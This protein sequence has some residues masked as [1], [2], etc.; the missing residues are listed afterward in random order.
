M[1]I[2]EQGLFLIYAFCAL[3]L[4]VYGMNCYVMVLLFLRV[5]R[6]ER[7]HWHEV[8]KA[9]EELWKTP[10]RLPIVTTQIPIFNEANVS[11]RIIRA[12]AAMD[13]PKDLHEIQVL[14]DSTDETK[15]LV[16]EV[17]TS[18]KE[19]GYRIELFHRTNRQGYKAGALREGMDVCAGEFIAIFDADFVP[20]QN[21]LRQMV[22]AIMSDSNLGF[23]QARWG[24][25]NSNH[26]L[27]TRSQTIGIDGHFMIEQCARAY[28]RLFL[29]FNGTA[30]LWRKQ[31]I[32]EAGNWQ[33]DTL[34][35]DMD[36]SYRC[37]LAGWDASYVPDVVVPAELPESY[38]A[39]KSQQF[40]WAKGSIQT[41]IKILP[42]V[43]CSKSSMLAKMQAF[44]HLT[45]YSIHPLMALMALLAL[46]VLLTVSVS[47][48]DWL[49]YIWGAGIVASMLGPSAM[50]W[51]SQMVQGRENVKR[52]WFLPA[53]MCVGVGIALSNTRAVLEAITRRKSAFV[54]TPKSGLQT[55]VYR[56]KVGWLPLLEV[57]LGIYCFS[58][59]FVYMQSGKY[60]VGPF[61][62]IYA[63]G[64][65][66]VGLRSLAESFRRI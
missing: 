11:E 9:G 36:L 42:R 53:L 6:R 27:L 25:L 59:L 47:V 48:P 15:L 19:E 4:L 35:E 18:L 41:A 55:K 60:L 32:Y 29:N 56:S 2:L 62:L 23:L 13:Y 20:P 66:F 45:H 51:V 12:V 38:A 21:Y 3:G 52:L 24:H 30:G 64:F 46:P 40:R 10:E 61:L 37:Q 16:E 50:Y 8:M 44:L 34:T 49:L 1:N 63:L 39:F 33:D 65:L 17:V 57:A 43:L 7:A 31:A 28:N 5:H 22:P 26:S 58:S 54:R 14:D